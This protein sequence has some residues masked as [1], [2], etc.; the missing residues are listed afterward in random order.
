[1]SFKFDWSRISANKELRE[2][3]REQINATIQKA[4]AE[5]ENHSIRLRTL[6]FGTEPP[7]LQIAKINELK[8]DKVHL[9]FAFAYKGNASLSFDVNLQV[10]PLVSS[11]SRIGHLNRTHMGIL[12]SH[13]PLHASIDITLSKF[14]IDGTIDL[15]ITVP[16]S[17]PTEM[18]EQIEYEEI[19]VTDDNNILPSKD[20]PKTLLT[21][22]REAFRKKI[23]ESLKYTNLEELTKLKK[24]KI[25]EN[26]KTQ[27]KFTLLNE[28]FKNVKINTT[29]DGSNASIKIGNTI[30]KQLRTN[31]KK[32][33]GKPQTFEFLLPNNKNT[34]ETPTG[35][36]SSSLKSTVKT[37]GV[38]NTVTTPSSNED[39]VEPSVELR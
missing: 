21:K 26:K 23:M 9:V 35:Q 5:N 39:S 38:I 6:D 36:S 3:L 27:I 34:N 11:R 10:N 2:Q 25:E 7:E 18:E 29:F 22:S 12:S 28:A 1:M 33:V 30:K 32:I 37:P 8:C 24:P 13:L 16:K 4:A 20:L 14:Q 17:S 31:L 19:Y 15:C